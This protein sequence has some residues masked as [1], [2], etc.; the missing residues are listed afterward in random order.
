[1]LTALLGSLLLAAGPRGERPTRP[2]LNRPGASSFV[3]EIDGIE[4]GSF[5]TVEGLG[6]RLDVVPFAGGEDLLL[7][8][9]GEALFARVTL[10]AGAPGPPLVEWQQEVAEGEAAPRDVEL[11]MRLER[12]T[13][14]WRAGPVPFCRWKLPAAR[15]AALEEQRVVLEGDGQT[16]IEWAACPGALWPKNRI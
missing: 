5:R 15:L 2:A 14:T 13:A 7:E 9:L 12:D 6:A 11:V 1:M 3:V 10:A 8:R 16:P 4:A